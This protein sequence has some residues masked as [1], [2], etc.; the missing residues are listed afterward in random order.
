MN[1]IAC[2]T[3]E[4]VTFSVCV[5]MCVMVIERCSLKNVRFAA[6]V[7]IERGIMAI[8]LKRRQMWFFE[9]VL[10]FRH[11]HCGENITRYRMITGVGNEKRL[12][13]VNRGSANLAKND[14][15]LKNK[16]PKI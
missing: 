9:G 6:I 7:A 10:P 3:A 12:I 15:L 4:D 13:K 1:K 8:A 2:G 14:V 5:A 16:M 11:M